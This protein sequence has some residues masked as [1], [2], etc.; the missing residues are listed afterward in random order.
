MVVEA[1]VRQYVDVVHYDQTS[2]HQDSH[3]AI[4]YPDNAGLINPYVV[5]CPTN[6]VYKQHSNSIRVVKKLN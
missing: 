4:Y 2:E 1:V 5:I 3:P 6:H